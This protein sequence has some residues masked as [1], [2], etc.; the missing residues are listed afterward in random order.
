MLDAN[1]QTKI[2][3]RWTGE[4]STNEN[5]RLTRSDNNLNYSRLS[6]WYLQ[7]GDY[8]R[9]KVVTLGYTLPSTISENIGATKVRFYVTGENLFTFTKYTGYDPEIAAG[10]SFGID[11]LAHEECNYW[12]NEKLES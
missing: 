8:F 10:D 3:E 5:P 1:Y 4:G 2:L 7:K 11:R 6:N 12:L 9:I